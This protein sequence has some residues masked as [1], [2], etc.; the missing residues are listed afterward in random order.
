MAFPAPSS[1]KLLISSAVASQ[2]STFRLEITTFAPCFA[3]AIAIDLPMPL[4]EP[5]IIAFLPVK[6]NI[7]ILLISLSS[8]EAF[9]QQMRLDLL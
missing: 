4:D 9:F 8:L 3:I 2:T 5:V 6:S 1:F 7:S